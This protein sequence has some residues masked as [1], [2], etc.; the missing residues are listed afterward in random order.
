[1]EIK[2]SDCG[3]G[4]ETRDIIA[5][6]D[7]LFCSQC[8]PKDVTKKFFTI[9]ISWVGIN[10]IVDLIEGDVNVDQLMILEKMKTKLEFKIK[11]AIEEIL[12]EAQISES[13]LKSLGTGDGEH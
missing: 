2:C 11:E 10:A 7:G 8:L 6:L 4:F 5:T 13:D 3:K 1:M 9:Q 12:R